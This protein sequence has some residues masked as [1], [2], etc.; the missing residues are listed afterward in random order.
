MSELP[1]YG[2]DADLKAKQEAKFD[3]GLEQEV[4]AWIEEITG[5]KRG[6]EQS[7]AEWLKNGHVL[8]SL[9][10]KIK[11]GAVKK[12]NASA[13][14]FK[15]MENITFFMNHARDLGV[16]E[17][18]MFGTPDLYEEKNMNTVMSCLY[19]YGGVVQVACPEFEGPKLGDPVAAKSK[20]TKRH[21][22]PATQSGGLSSAMEVQ[23]VGGTARQVA[24]GQF[25]VQ[26]PPEGGADAQGLDADLKAK[27]AAKY[28]VGLESEVVEWIEGVTGEAKGDQAVHEWLKNGQ[29][30][31]KLINAISPDKIKKINAQ[32]MPFKQMENITFFMNAA[33]DLGVP[34]S[35]M[36]GTPDLYEEK[37]MGSVMTCLNSL[38]SAVQVS[39]PGFAGPKLGVAMHVSSDDKKREGKMA[40]SQYEAMERTL[41]VERPKDGGITRGANV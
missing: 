20:D 24:A 2:L 17:S 18:S 28:D 33:R 39:C 8:C 29:I 32:S 22:G 30:L 37:N 9:A 27:Q 23:K 13:M 38:G 14:P 31:C 34:E 21:V 41:E 36:F 19:T 25:G 10:N 35:S 11:P 7:A 1:S 12:V 40:T 5:E 16:P 15:Q 3:A 26:A 6:E 4:C